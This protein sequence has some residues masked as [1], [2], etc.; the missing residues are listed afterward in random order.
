MKPH[1]YRV[2]GAWYC[3]QDFNGFTRVGLPA[4]TPQK[5]YSCFRAYW[6]KQ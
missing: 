2:N 4:S 1:L 3:K 6:S 5:A